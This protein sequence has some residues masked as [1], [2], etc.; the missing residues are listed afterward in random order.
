MQEVQGR[1]ISL[2]SFDEA[3]RAQ[4]NKKKWKG[5]TDSKLIRFLTKLTEIHKQTDSKVI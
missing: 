2:L 4:K 1:I 3:R 5:H